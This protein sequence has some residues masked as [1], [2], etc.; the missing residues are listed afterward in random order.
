PLFSQLVDTLQKGTNYFVYDLGLDIVLAAKDLLQLPD[1]HDR[2]IV[3]TAKIA[4][5]PIITRDRVIKKSNYISV[6]W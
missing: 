6:I 3:A 5:S 2:L 4:Q 1:I